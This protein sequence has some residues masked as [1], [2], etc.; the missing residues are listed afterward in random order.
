MLVQIR[1]ELQ[2]KKSPEV[3][4]THIGAD[5]PQFDLRVERK[6]SA[7]RHEA[8]E[9]V[10]VEM[11]FMSRIGGPIRIRIMRSDYFYQT[12][13]LSYTVKFADKRHNVGHVLN[14]VTTDDLVEFVVRKGIGESSKVVNDVRMGP[15]V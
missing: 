9:G 8:G 13:R 6:G 14:N 2:S 7:I 15:R 4:Q 10:A 12:R 1:N 5:G 11:I 3:G